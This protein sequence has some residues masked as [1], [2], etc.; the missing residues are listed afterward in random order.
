MRPQPGTYPVYFENY[1]KLVDSNS[2][3]E[4]IE[5]YSDYFVKFFKKIR[6]SNADYRYAPGK[7]SLKELLQHIIDTERIFA[8]RA[9]CIARK[10]TTPLPGFDE[11]SYA[12]ESKADQRNWKTLVKE[13]KSVRKSTNNLLNSLDDEQLQQIGNTNNGQSNTA[14]A[15]SFVIFGHIIHH[16]NVVKER[17]LQ[18]Q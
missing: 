7:W 12:A 1:I 11:N 9:L 5:K 4:A 14:L 15:I 2:I 8:Y 16:M 10:D 13:F 6:E 18:E 3:A 17:Y